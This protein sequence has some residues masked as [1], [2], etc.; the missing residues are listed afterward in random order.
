MKNPYLSE[1]IRVMTWSHGLHTERLDPT[2]AE[3]WYCGELR[4]PLWKC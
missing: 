2:I 3:H 4:C 1:R